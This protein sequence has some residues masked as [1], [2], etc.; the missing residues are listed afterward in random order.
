ML[1]L[2]VMCDILMWLSIRIGTCN[3]CESGCG[4]AVSP[5]GIF[6]GTCHP[7]TLKSIDNKNPTVCPRSELAYKT[8]DPFLT[9]K[10]LSDRRLRTSHFTIQFT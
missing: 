2:E 3:H 6:V 8:L 7:T 1:K 9:S 4:H 10:P 5:H